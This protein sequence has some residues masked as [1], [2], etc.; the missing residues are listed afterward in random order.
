MAD[1][2]VFNQLRA[3]VYAYDEVH[4]RLAD[5]RLTRLDSWTPRSEVVSRKAT[6]LSE[7]GERTA[8]R[9]LTE[10]KDKYWPDD[11]RIVVADT[12]GSRQMFADRP[13]LI[14]ETVSGKPVLEV[15]VQRGE[16][17]AAIREYAATE[18]IEIRDVTGHVY[19]QDELTRLRVG[20]L[21]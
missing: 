3:G 9:Y 13:G 11:P 21:P 16:V 19:N 17:P 1:G 2:N 18:R 10:F 5:R 20:N 12:V 7:V 6:Q 14:G 8:M 15:P 4:L